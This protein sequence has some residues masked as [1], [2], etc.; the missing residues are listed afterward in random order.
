[1]DYIETWKR[2]MGVNG[3]SVTKALKKNSDYF[4][5]KEFK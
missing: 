3:G 4:Y 5:N 1:M 2:K